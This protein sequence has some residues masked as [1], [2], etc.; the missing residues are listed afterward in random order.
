MLFLIFLHFVLYSLIV[1]LC[2]S[3]LIWTAGASISSLAVFAAN[4]G[5][6]E[7]ILG[8]TGND[9]V[10]LS[11]YQTELL[12]GAVFLSVG[13][14]VAI[15]GQAVLISLSSANIER[16]GQRARQYLG[17]REFSKERIQLTTGSG[18]GTFD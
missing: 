6:S 13:F 12:D 3:V 11:Q 4:V 9:I 14:F 2:F 15:V 1:F 17:S 8:L 16:L 18:G 5:D 10:A 7:L